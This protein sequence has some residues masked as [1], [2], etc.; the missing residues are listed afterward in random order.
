MHSNGS[1]TAL[2]ISIDYKNYE[3]LKTMPI[4]M[5]SYIFGKL[6]ISLVLQLLIT[7]LIYIAYI[8]VLGTS[9]TFL[10]VGYITFLVASITYSLQLF[11]KDVTIPFTGW[12]NITQLLMRGASNMKQWLIF[13]GFFIASILIVF[14][15]VMFTNFFPHLWWALS[16]FF[17]LCLLAWT[18]FVVYK[19]N[20]F[21]LKN[22][23]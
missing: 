21:V 3:F 18:S 16:T 19:F 6:N 4:N 17:V 12:S 11:T 1:F 5:K 22:L 13:L 15:T 9:T 8:L 2:S 10:V 20:K 23:D 14:L 7:S